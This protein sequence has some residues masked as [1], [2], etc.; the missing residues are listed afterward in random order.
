MRRYLLA[1]VFIV[2]MPTLATADLADG[3]QAFDAGDYATAYA[4]WRPLAEAGDPLA[5]VALANLYAQGTGVPR[6]PAKAAR[7]YAL[8]AE[9]GNV[10]GQLNLG[11]YYARGHGVPRDLVQAYMWLE[12][13]ARQGHA[14]ATGR[15]DEVAGG[16]SAVQV[17]GARLKADRFSPRQD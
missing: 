10:T 11:D 15:R 1:I 3:L 8:A 6:D 14:W 4:E 17:V 16:M 9:Q 12:L 5:Q 7:W 2:G 13:A